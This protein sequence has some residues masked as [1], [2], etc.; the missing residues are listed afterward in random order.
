MTAIK[1][2]YQLG[3]KVGETLIGARKQLRFVLEVMD[4]DNHLDDD[5][6]FR[7]GLDATALC[8]EGCD[9]WCEADRFSVTMSVPCADCAKINGDEKMIDVLLTLLAVWLFM[10]NMRLI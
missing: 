10:K 9:W 6:D 4:L 3:V 5:L 2:K 7:A 8:C 1:T